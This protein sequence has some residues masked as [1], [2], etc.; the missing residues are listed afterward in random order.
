VSARI[1]VVSSAAAVAALLAMTG[2]AMAQDRGGSLG[3]AHRTFESP[4]HFAFEFRFSPYRPDIDS[5]PALGGHQ[6]FTEIFGTTPRILVA[7][8][9]DWQVVRIPHVGTFGPG[10]SAGY[11]SMGATAPLRNPAPP[12]ASPLS[13]EQTSLDIFP[14]YAVAVLRADVLMREAN[15]PLVPYVK[16]GLGYALWRASNDSGTS[17]SNGVAGKGHSYGTQLA[18]GLSLHLNAFDAYAAKEFDN[19]MGVNH[20]YLFFEY[21]SSNFSTLGPASQLRVGATT[22]AMGLAFEF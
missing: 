14:F 15:I 4:Q 12:P 21:F 6:P 3:S 18:L 10:I 16:A 22:W 20:T 7:A 11:T 13:G 2:E 5:D 19:T 1:I 8:E 9:L 17:S